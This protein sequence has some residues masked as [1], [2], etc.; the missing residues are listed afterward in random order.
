[1]MMSAGAGLLS[2]RAS[3]IW[4]A[5][6]C[7]VLVFH[8]GHLIRMRGE[9]RWYH[10]AHVAMLLGMLYMYAAMAF[11]LDLLPAH[12]WLIIYIATSA[13]VG[14]WIWERFRR[15]RSIGHLWI[16]ALV[17]QGAM[18][19]MWAPG[20]YWLPMVS[21]AFAAYF[22]LETSAWL[23]RACIRP[24]P[25]A[26]VAGRGGSLVMPLAHGSVRGDICMAIMAA[27]MGYMFVGMQLMMSVQ[28][29]SEPLAQQ[30][31]LS[32]SGPT[33]F[34]SG[35]GSP[36][37]RPDLAVK[38]PARPTVETRPP[39]TAETHT[40]T[41]GDSLARIAARRYGDARR[42]PIILKANPGLNP[43]QLRIGRAIKLPAAPPR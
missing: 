17:Q 9:R 22:A 14:I 32:V 11:G 40:I 4:I 16:A 29:Q 37:E 7:V 43:R 21:Y 39:K 26:A 38:E 41:A 6:L 28:R 12:V 5:A 2:A 24:A 19:Y 42:W 18:I 30:Q 23:M 27:S 10:C 13:A 3:A 1:M 20:N 33:G 15:R 35:S 34:A 36:A 25:G 8:C 31:H